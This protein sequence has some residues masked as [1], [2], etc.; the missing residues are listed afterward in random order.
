MG[1]AWRMDGLKAARQN[2]AAA[3]K[4]IA[5]GANSSVDYSAQANGIAGNLITLAY[6][7]PAG[8]NQALGVVV[9]G[10]A[11]TVNLATGAGGAITSTATLIRAAIAASSPANALIASALTAG[12][13]GSGVVTAVGAQ[14][15]AGGRDPYKVGEMARLANVSDRLIH[16]LDS[17]GTCSGDEA[18]R[19]ADALGMTRAS[20]AQQL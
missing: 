2:G 8:N 17:G 12:H 5:A 9:V 15:F 1:I 20:L 16:A 14:A 13:D 19:I 18:Q 3:T 6:V 7:D 10:N 11:I 4:T